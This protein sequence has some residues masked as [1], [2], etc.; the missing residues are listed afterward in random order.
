MSSAWRLT[1]ACWTSTILEGSDERWRI[2][3]E[4]MKANQVMVKAEAQTPPF[5]GADD[6]DL[7][8]DIQQE[9]AWLTAT[10]NSSRDHRCCRV[11]S[12]AAR[13]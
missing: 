12:G 4:R 1:P 7:A 8:H 6:P 5:A 2:E 13:A 3:D 10:S 11:V 9:R